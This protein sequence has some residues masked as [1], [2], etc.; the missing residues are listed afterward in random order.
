MGES[1]ATPN[2][3]RSGWRVLDKSHMKHKQDRGGRGH[4]AVQSNHSR[5]VL[6]CR[7]EIFEPRLKDPK[8][9]CLGFQIQPVGT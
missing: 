1:E 2:S 8:N 4:A 7:G 5:F 6:G 9:G 3:W